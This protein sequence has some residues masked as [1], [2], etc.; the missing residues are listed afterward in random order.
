MGP[1]GDGAAQI[2]PK[3]GPGR[4]PSATPDADE[5]RA[6]AIEERVAAARREKL[7]I[8]P[9]VPPYL[10][11]E[12]ASGF[13]Y[14]VRL[15]GV[16]ASRL[17]SCECPDF[18]ANRLHT[19]KH[20][21]RVRAHLGSKRT[22][23]PAPHVT[24]AERGAVY[25][26]FG[27]IVEPCL[28]GVP[29][30]PGSRRVTSAFDE[31]G[32]SRLPMACDESELRSRLES[33]EPWVDPDAKAWV[34]RRLA[35]APELPRRDF[36]QLVGD[37]HRQPYP[38]QWVGARFLAER[39]R[40]LLADEMGLGK[41]VQAI[42]AA[43]ALRRATRPA[44]AV[45]VVCPVSLR[46][47]WRDE[48]R[49]WLGDEAVMLEGPTPARAERIAARP[50]WLI[51]HFEQVLKDHRHHAARPPDLLIIDEAQRAKGLATRTARVLEAIDAPYVF[52]L[53]GTPL[54]NRLEEAYAIAQLI[55][56]RLLP[57]LWQFDRDHF[58]R[59]ESGR[60]VVFYRNL[61]TLRSRLSPAFLRRRKEDVSL[62]LPPRVRSVVKVPMH[63]AVLDTYDDVM[64]SVARIASKKV[65][66][67]ADLERMQRL[68]VIAR[69]RCDGPHMLGMEIDARTVPK[70]T[71]LEQ[72][73]RDL[74]LGERRKAVVFSEWTDMTLAVEAL[75]D[76]LRI[77]AIH[78][79]GN[80]PVARRPELIRDFT[81]RRGPAVFVSTDAGGVGLNL[82][83]AD[84]V[85]N[86]DLPWNPARLEQRIARA[87]RIGSKRTVQE[88][89]FVAQNVVEERILELHATKRDVLENVWA[90]GG[91][92]QIAAPGGSGAF[93]Q[94]VAALLDTRGPVAAP[95]PVDA[96][97]PGD[98]APHEHAVGG[99]GD[100]ID[101]GAGPAPSVEASAESAPPQ[102]SPAPALAAVP[103]ADRAGEAVVVDPGAVAAA[104]AAVAPTLPV[105]HRRS[106]ATVFRALADALDG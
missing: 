6:R 28:W 89:L 7:A 14:R 25:L 65:I 10:R 88:I 13:S 38:Y 48:I 33:F 34:D 35:R 54:E 78:L 106:L 67:P 46:G 9:D 3:A 53:T 44:R 49:A 99:A 37:L 100:V 80:V 66:L 21:E 39:G 19:C 64:H 59:D 11:V 77:P 87:H 32:R 83:A 47:G 22:R 26:H 91:E 61:D 92:D 95:E 90:S 63:P 62:E 105:A 86:L 55:D 51:T 15:R 84:V 96:L 58:V 31:W 85:I 98:L 102:T 23:L 52:A 57:P 5:A 17:H 71:E 42:L 79:H 93:R 82:Q 4:A 29:R 73:L 75:C 97:G 56:Q 12:G 27:E 16:A 2:H 70:L 50:S 43:A 101:A 81:E 45:T 60:R 1:D 104:I 40:A 8:T 20:V 94:M 68:L 41:T 69:R 72:A 18:E 24:A 76:R 30:G 103:D 36:A 74:C